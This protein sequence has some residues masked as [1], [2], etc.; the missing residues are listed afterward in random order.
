MTLGSVMTCVC[1]R[2]DSLFLSLFHAPC[3]TQRG[4]GCEAP[5]KICLPCFLF[6]SVC[7]CVVVSQQ[8]RP[9]SRGPGREASLWRLFGTRFT[10]CWPVRS[11]T[12]THTH[13]IICESCMRA[14][15]SGWMLCG[16]VITR[17]LPIGVETLEI[18]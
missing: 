9:Q 11:H 12:Y 10:S 7:V 17:Q 13:S 16:E 14:P 4:E 1:H 3:P 8:H 5:S 18:R 2:Q 6:M 15:Y